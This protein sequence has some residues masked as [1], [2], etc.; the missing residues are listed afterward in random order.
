M[1]F[2]FMLAVLALLLLPC[3]ALAAAPTANFTVTPSTGYAPLTVTIVN[4]STG[5]PTDLNYSFGDG[6]ANSTSTLGFTHTFQSAGT[7]TIT[8]FANN[9]DGNSTK[10]NTV[11]V[12]TLSGLTVVPNVGSVY[13]LKTYSTT[14]PNVTISSTTGGL[15]NS[16]SN[17]ITS[18]YTL[19]SLAILALAAAAILRY[20]GYF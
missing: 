13:N 14:S 17:V 1:K 8:L 20:L 6:S 12:N 15:Y 19:A 18:G 3:A 11:T 16:V 10:V 5:A 2:R 4:V 7:Y 9:S